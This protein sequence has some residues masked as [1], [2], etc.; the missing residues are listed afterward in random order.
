MAAPGI[1]KVRQRL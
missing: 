1:W